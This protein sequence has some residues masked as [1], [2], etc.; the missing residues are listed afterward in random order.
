MGKKV[1]NLVYTI[2]IIFLILSFACGIIAFG[3]LGYSLFWAFV[4]GCAFVYLSIKLTLI[5]HELGHA[6]CGYLTG[7]RLVSLG[8]GRFLLVKKSGKFYFSRTAVFK[9]V[10]AQYIGIKE[11][12]SDQ[13]IILMLSGGLLVHLCLM[14]LAIL[15]GF[16]TQ[17][18]YFAAIWII[19]NLSLFLTN[20]LPIGITD[21][22]KI[23]ELWQSPENVNYAYMS[24]RHSAQTILA[25]EEC[26][27]KDFV[28]PVSENAQGFF[29]ENMLVQQG[30]VFLLEGKLKEAKQQ[31][32]SILEQ[33]DNS[34]I[35]A[36]AQMSLL[37]IAL[38]EDKVETAEEYASILKLKPF[39]SLKMTHIQTMQ[40]WYQ[41]K[42]KK[43]LAKTHKAIQIAREKMN[44]SYL[45]RDEK[46]YY[47]NWLAKL[48]KALSEGI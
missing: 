44:A 4:F 31:F 8:I 23:W 42:V 11:D 24:L 21:G 2:A 27:L 45:L 38:L 26:D 7:Y 34:L 25:P 40:A 48:E 19:L 22:A 20:A 36:I 5:L 10:S 29:A 17:T 13:R 9:N 3:E 15:F 28:M 41:Y 32:Q 18:W 43:D 14:L 35:Q 1:I 6:F 16:L 46:R 47:E 39:L 33:T 30:Q 12:E 37:H